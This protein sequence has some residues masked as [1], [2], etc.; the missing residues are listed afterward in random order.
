MKAPKIP[1]KDHEIVAFEEKLNWR[2]HQILDELASRAA[3][4][5]YT[6]GYEEGY[7]D[8]RQHH[9]NAPDRWPHFGL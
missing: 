7:A 6:R 9:V 8:G 4:K 2:E 5:G 1:V 3:E